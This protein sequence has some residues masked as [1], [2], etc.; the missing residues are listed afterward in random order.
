MGLL[1]QMAAVDRLVRRPADLPGLVA[2]GGA[3]AAVLSTI[4]AT[5][6]EA[7]ARMQAALTLG[8][9]WQ[10]RWTGAVESL[11]G[12]LGQEALATALV[13]SPRFE[14]AEGEDVKGSAFALAVLD[15]I[16]SGATDEAPWLPDLLAYEYLLAFGLPRRAQGLDVDAEVEARLLA[17]AR[18]FEGGRLARRVVALPVA[19]PVG[20]WHEGTVED[21]DPEPRV[22]ALAVVEDE[23]VEVEAPPQA[24]EALGMLAEGADDKAIAAR[25]GKKNATRL[26]GWL[27]DA[28]MLS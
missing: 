17:T 1:E 12:A 24:V 21:E 19:W 3:D 15:L 28:E 5:R 27:R 16:D 8:R 23:V 13:A 10:P 6:L 26:M 18:W 9:W 14:R 11:A 7:V 22:H 2:A 20:A 4:D 25:L